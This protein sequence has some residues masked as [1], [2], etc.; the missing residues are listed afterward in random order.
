MAGWLFASA[1]LLSAAIIGTNP[2]ASPLSAG[3]IA[4]LPGA[5]QSAWLEYLKRSA[6][7]GRADQAFLQA[8]L[9]RQGIRQPGVPPA[10]RSTRNLPL[11]APA[12]WYA[13]PEARR[14]ADNVVSFQTPAGGWSKNLDLSQHPR[15]PG[16][17]FAPDSSTRFP[18][19]GDFDEERA[20][21]WSYI[22][23]FDNGA[24]ITELRFLAKVITAATN[25]PAAWRGSFQRGLDYIFDAQYPNGG[26]PQIW[27]LQGGYHDAIT[28]NDNAMVNVL[29]LLRDV[30][31]TNREFA[32][33]PGPYRQRAAASLQ[34]G[35][36][37]VLAT[38][39]AVAGRRTVWCQQHD[40]LTLL[41]T[42][43]RN[44]EMPSQSG[45][46]SA[47]LLMFLMQ[48]PDPG[49][50]V[51]AA[52]N[53][54]AAWFE[55]TAIPDAALARQG[56]GRQLVAAPGKGPVWARYYEIGTDRP[57]FGNR[58]KTIHDRLDEITPERRNGYSWYNDVPRVALARYAD[59]KKQ[60]G[61]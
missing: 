58:D 60:P 28:Y 3:R 40:P 30:S 24:T 34:R 10:G 15:A 31:G 33:V 37:C 50:D 2:P 48:L 26:W 36:A 47:G 9:R 51:V 27:P 8:E 18:L 21:H 39:I 45:A 43:A 42:S 53:D 32:F 49:P 56:D 52:V 23:T 6:G 12:T 54:A 29:L 61:R 7:Q 14:L 5:R 11:N 46:E 41:P 25:L 13:D 19:P 35:I 38:R 59:W 55:K 4:A 17:N 44:Y 57:I 22:G 20:P 16:E 1:T